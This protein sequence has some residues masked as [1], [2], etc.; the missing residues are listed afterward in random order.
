MIKVNKDFADVPKILKSQNRK[1]AFDKNISSN[2]YTDEKNL[3]KVGSVQKK[4]NEIYYLKC[5]YCEQKLLDAPKH[6]EHYR[7]KD[8]YYWLAYSWDNLLLSC[9]RC[10]S[11]KGIKFQV[12]KTMVTY[13][14]ESFEDIH[15]FGNSYDV[16]EEPMIIN[17]EKEDVLDKLVFDKEGNISSLDDRVIYTIC[18]VCNLNREELVQKRVKILNDFINK[19]NKHYFLFLKKGDLSRFLPDIK[20]F[21]DECNVRNEFYSFRYFIIN[22]IEIF[23]ED[24]NIQKILKALILKSKN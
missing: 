22:Y 10:N 17:P 8:I 24:E 11:S 2:Q 1:D 6:I 4:L 21:L 9:G 13:N 15:S 12:K 14:N 3:Y 5:A 7:P 19:I 23:F 16:I 18:D 20:F